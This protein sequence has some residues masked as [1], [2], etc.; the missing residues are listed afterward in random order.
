[1]NR[2]PSLE[3]ISSETRRI[4]VTVSSMDPKPADTNNDYQYEP[5]R[6]P[7]LVEL[8]SMNRRPSLQTVSSEIRR[9]LRTVRSMD[10]ATGA[11]HQ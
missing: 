8:A 11:E 2:R 10:P 7:I 4:L 5:R 6:L 3:T 1:M 9:T